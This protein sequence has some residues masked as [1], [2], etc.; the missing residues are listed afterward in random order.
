MKVLIVS[1]NR[2]SRPVVVLPIGACLVA[3]AA[4]RA[5][6]DVRLL[7]M[8]FER[9]PLEALE[10][11][12]TAIR[13]DVV[14]F[15]LRNIDNNDMQSPEVYYED[16]PAAVAAVRR[17]TSA[18]VVVGGGAV[19]VMPQ[20]LL[21]HSG[22]D[23]AVLSDGDAVLPKLL[24]ALARGDDVRTIPRVAWLDG[25]R[26]CVAPGRAPADPDAPPAPA[27]CNWLDVRPYLRRFATVPV[28]TKRG[29]PFECAYCTYPIIEGRHYRL[30]SPE[31]VVDAV[32]ALARQGVR[33]VEFVDNV[34]NSPYEHALA[35]CQ[36][37]ARAGLS[38]RLQAES[39][40]PRFVDDGLLDAM[41]AAGFVG[42]G[43]TVESAA[44]PCLEALQKGFTAEDVGRSAEAVRR[45][46]LP[47]VWI[48][49]LGG[50]RE[51]QATV[52]E[53]LR[54]AN[55]CLRP[56]DAAF[57]SVGIRVY[58]GTAIEGRARAEGQLDGDGLLH[59]MFYLSP[60]L[61]AG[62][63]MDVLRSSARQ[64]MG[65]VMPDSVSV[66][67]LPTVQALAYRF[68]LRPPLWRH[69]SRLRRILKLL[70]KDV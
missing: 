40:S 13:P 1:T 2:C 30:L 51:T 38:M 43:I 36:G 34:F 50:P 14:G 27:V 53:T 28:Q 47:C 39:L 69:A 26:L 17:L 6:H 23:L 10:R 9:H 25:N 65:F 63:L 44:Q 56:G 16:L 54:F 66:P 31:A 18:R 62:W 35:I 48:F 5:G 12:L 32:R 68:G 19:S 7:D 59:P 58:P 64:N 46:G 22:A 37:I 67:F 55:A 33:D 29:C 11:E 3:E 61:D 52:R 21:R 60:E 42:I 49:M 70:G 45:H 15:S 24:G 41:S 20:A 8:M 4:Q 57:F